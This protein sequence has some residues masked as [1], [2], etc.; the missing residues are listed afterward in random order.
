MRYA[1]YYTPSQDDALTRAATAWLGRCA[2][3]GEVLPPRATATMS[4][5]EIA[6]HTA[7]ARRYGFHATMMAPFTLAD[8]E[9]E[10]ALVDALDTVCRTLPPVSVPRLVLRRLD[11]FFA[12]MPEV[13][14]PDLAALAG[15]VVT[16][17]DRFRAPLG[18]SERKRRAA[19]DL[20]PSQLRNLMRWGYPYIF[21]DFRFH[22]TLSGRVD[23]AD[24]A[25]VQRAIEDHF[26]PL[27]DAPRVLGSLALFLEPEPG[28]PFIVRSFHEFGCVTERKF[29]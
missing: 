3:T 25:R 6:Y 20:T 22:M 17:F 2:F 14:G 11:G 28:A 19:S 27:L 12:L 18:D 5:A 24:A 1:V 26:G 7:A 29:A 9:S 21:D 4:A 13:Q 23:H 16:A 8:T 10:C 15:D